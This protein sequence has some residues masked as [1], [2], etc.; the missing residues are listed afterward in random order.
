MQVTFRS[1]CC[2]YSCLEPNG[3]AAGTLTLSM[4]RGVGDLDSVAHDDCAARHEP[5]HQSERAQHPLY[6]LRAWVVPH[7]AG[8]RDHHRHHILRPKLGT[9]L[10][11][12]FGKVTDEQ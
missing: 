11:L 9:S 12:A 3:V 1:R 10:S 4:I 7:R 6:H 5:R 2:F 8:A